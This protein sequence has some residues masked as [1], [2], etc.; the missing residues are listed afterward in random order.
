[1]SK[2]AFLIDPIDSL[3]LHH[4]SSIGMMLAS[5]HL[6]AEVFFFEAQDLFLKDNEAY[7]HLTPLLRG[8]LDKAPWYQQGMTGVRALKDMDVI[9]VRKDPPFNIDYVFMT[10]LLD[11]AV[12]DG[13]Y[14]TNPPKVL[15]EFNEKMVIFN[16]PDLIAPSIVSCNKNDIRHFWEQHGDIVL[17]PLDGM[18]GLNVFHLKPQDTNFSV[19]CEILTQHGKRHVMAQKYLPAVVQG[20][21]R[22]VLFYGEPVEKVLVRIPQAGEVRANT[23]AG[24][25][26]EF[27]DLS[28]R[29]RE[30]CARL[31]PFLLQEDISLVGLDL[32]G[33]YVTE[34]NVT[35]P[36]AMRELSQV[37]GENLLLQYMKKVLA[38]AKK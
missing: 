2:I 22:V 23:A 3:L 13:V 30:V 27:D 38:C 12:R 19:A 31:K 17:K 7:A 32:I 29:D 35:S 10:Y 16:F 11:L 9:V 1:M 8:D 4:D 6:Q 14:V 21:R 24:G 34:I 25:R 36:T 15:R 20:D 5:L 26:F 33:G 28:A 18:G 37:L